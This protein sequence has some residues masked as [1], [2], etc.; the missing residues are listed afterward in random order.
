MP[1]QSPGF[2]PVF[3][4]I[5]A[6][7]AALSYPAAQQIL[8]RFSR[9]RLIVIDHY[10]DVFSRS[11]QDFS[12]QKRTPNLILAVKRSHLVY[13]GAPTCQNFGNRRFFYTS[14]VMNCLYDCEYCYLQGMYPS[15]NLVVFVNL[16][17]LF[18]AA[19]E[20]LRQDDTYLCISYD[21]D[22]LALEPWLG[23]VGR[24]AE[25]ARAHPKALVELRTKS[26]GFSSMRAIPPLENFILAFTLSPSYVASRWE[27][28]APPPQLRIRAAADAMAAGW[29]VRISFDPALRFPSW[30]SAYDQLFAQTFSSLL[31][32]ALEDVSFGS[33]RVPGDSL[34]RMRKSRPRSAPLQYPYF[35]EG[36]VARYAPDQEKE[37]EAFFLSRLSPLLPPEKIFQWK[38]EG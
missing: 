11:R 30:K 10:K 6:E 1:V 36:G 28:R 34:K 33:F 32:Q 21:T 18:S 37:L 7:R 20:L 31:P 27:H 15:A 22:L 24:W 5:Y 13:P 25:W 14:S 35:N 23:Y 4:H 9:S 16:E 2:A 8:E 19:E 12:L 17:D 29:R 38:E 3:S 26:A